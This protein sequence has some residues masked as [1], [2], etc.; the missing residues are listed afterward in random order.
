MQSL[1]NPLPP[2]PSP[3][4]PPP[5]PARLCQGYVKIKVTDL[6]FSRNKKVQYQASYPVWQ[7]V[8]FFHP[9][10]LFHLL[11]YLFYLSSSFLWETTQND[12]QG[13]TCR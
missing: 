7:Q 4:P 3:Q 2:T 12:P 1:P 8:L 6:E 11:Y 10:L 5:N 9:V 13:F